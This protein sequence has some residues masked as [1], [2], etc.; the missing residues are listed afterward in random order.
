MLLLHGRPKFHSLVFSKRHS[1]SFENILW[2]TFRDNKTSG[3][4]I[5]CYTFVDL[6]KA[7]QF[8]KPKSGFAAF[9]DED[10][11]DS[12]NG[13]RTHSTHTQG[14]CKTTTIRTGN[15]VQTSTVCN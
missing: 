7:I 5:L 14:N 6:Y 2:S 3:S 11:E 1:P 15:T 10:E 12:G 9:F 4:S 8:Q 13:F